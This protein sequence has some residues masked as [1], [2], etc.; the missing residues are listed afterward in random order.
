MPVGIIADSFYWIL[1]SISEKLT[2]ELN[3]KITLQQ[4]VIVTVTSK[5][6]LL[7][8]LT[9][10]RWTL[11]LSFLLEEKKWERD[12][13]LSLQEISSYFSKEEKIT[14]WDLFWK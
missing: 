7:Q 5:G 11:E 4:I 9:Q 12:I 2:L 6:G 13:N 10:K 3:E 14:V 1:T 8:V